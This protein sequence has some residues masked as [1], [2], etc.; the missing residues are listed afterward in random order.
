[1]EQWIHQLGWKN[2]NEAANFLKHANSDPD[3]TYDVREGD[4]Q[5]GIGFAII[6]YRRL[7]G[8]YTP[9]MRAFDLWMK[10]SN[11]DK[12]KLPSDPDPAFEEAYRESVAFLKA[13]PKATQLML[14][15]ALLSYFREHPDG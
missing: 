13:A 6:L 5:M 9:E 1:M 2:F 10:I 4:T 12:F 7:S 3:G 14:P 11:P 15:Q 8:G